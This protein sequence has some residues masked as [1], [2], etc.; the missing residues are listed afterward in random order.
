MLNLCTWISFFGG[1]R[2][3]AELVAPAMATVS[4]PR[5]E[6]MRMIAAVDIAEAVNVHVTFKEAVVA[7]DALLDLL[8]AAQVRLGVAIN[9]VAREATPDHQ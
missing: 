7:V 8:R 3:P 1:R 2:T 5:A 6:L 4:K 9:A